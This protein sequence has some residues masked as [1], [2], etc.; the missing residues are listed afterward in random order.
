MMLKLTRLKGDNVLIDTTAIAVVPLEEGS[1][2][3]RQLKPKTNPYF[4]VKE[5]IEEIEQQIKE[6][7]IAREHYSTT[8]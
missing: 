8:S 1:R 3:F 6:G 5:T 7:G 4:D 2:I